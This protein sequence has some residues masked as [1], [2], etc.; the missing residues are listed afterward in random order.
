MAE[1]NYDVTV[2]FGGLK[3]KPLDTPQTKERVGYPFTRES[4]SANFRKQVG[5]QDDRAYVGIVF[6]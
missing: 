3:R 5:L 1:A 4:F 2:A 6:L